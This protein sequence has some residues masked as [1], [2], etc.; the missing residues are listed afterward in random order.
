MIVRFFLVEQLQ[1]LLKIMYIALITEQFTDNKKT[2][3]CNKRTNTVFESN[4][5]LVMKHIIK[6]LF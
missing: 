6:Q 2:K 3:T 5:L 4:K 1:I